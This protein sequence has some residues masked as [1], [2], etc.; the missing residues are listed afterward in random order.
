MSNNSINVYIYEDYLYKN[1]LPIINNRPTFEIRCGVYT[2]LDRLKLIL[3]NANISLIVRT[4]L[5][6]PIS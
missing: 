4:K 2:C 6:I 5:T 3:P 1:L